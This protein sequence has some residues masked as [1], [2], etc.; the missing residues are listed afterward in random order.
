MGG[1]GIARGSP[2]KKFKKLNYYWQ[3]YANV[4]FL[5]SAFD[6]FEGVGGGAPEV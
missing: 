6:F 3:T 1:G 4:V 5:I 2:F